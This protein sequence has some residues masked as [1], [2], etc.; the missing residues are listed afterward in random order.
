MYQKPGSFWMFWN[1]S[2]C[3]CIL[4]IFFWCFSPFVS[5]KCKYWPY[6]N[7]HS[8]FGFQQFT[9]ET[10]QL[11]PLQMAETEKR[12]AG[13]KVNPT[14]RAPHSPFF[15]SGRGP[16]CSTL[17]VFVFPQRKQN[18]INLRVSLFFGNMSWPRPQ[19]TRCTCQNTMWLR[20]R[21]ISVGGG[22]Q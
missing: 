22:H 15:L 7:P 12:V 4:Y 5:I 11:Q 19:N 8:P 16:P 3:W 21:Q 20:S 9:L 18:G 6:Q 10:L 14:Y 17:D 13:V 1:L 2:F